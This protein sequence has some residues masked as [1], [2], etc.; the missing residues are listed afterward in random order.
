M[1]TAHIF[2]KVFFHVAIPVKKKEKL[3]NITEIEFCLVV[4]GFANI[5]NRYATEQL[6]VIRMTRK[7]KET[8]QFDGECNWTDMAGT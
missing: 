2:P 6:N 3:L 1:Y 7:L 5:R 8:L 4:G